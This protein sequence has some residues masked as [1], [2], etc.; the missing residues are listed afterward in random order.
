MAGASPNSS[1]VRKQSNMVNSSTCESSGSDVLAGTLI[2]IRKAPRKPRIQR[3]ISTPASAPAIDSTRLSVSN[4]RI[5]FQRGAPNA[6][7]MEISFRRSVA[8]AS[9]IA[10]MLTQAIKSTNPATA[11]S[12]EANPMTGPRKAVPIRPGG[13][14][15]IWRPSL[16]RSVRARSAA[17]ELRSAS[18][19]CAVM[20]GFRRPATQMF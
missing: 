2:G 14:R 17:I 20:P 12:T 11:M 3:A 5:R 7:R 19:C 13:E 8:R 4:W 6:R 18:A 1:V 10:A 15:R 9:S 16:N